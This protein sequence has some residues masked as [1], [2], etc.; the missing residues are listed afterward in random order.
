MGV[1]DFLNNFKSSNAKPII[2]GTGRSTA[3]KF[4]GK[5]SVLPIDSEKVRY[6]KNS[7]GSASRG[8]KPVTQSNAGATQ[9]KSSQPTTQS[10]TRVGAF[11]PKYLGY[12]YQDA[13]SPGSSDYYNYVDPETG[14]MTGTERNP[15]FEFDPWTNKNKEGRN[16]IEDMIHRSVSNNSGKTVANSTKATKVTKPVVSSEPELRE[17]PSIEDVYAKIEARNPGWR[18]PGAAVDSTVVNNPAVSAVDS[19]VVKPVVSAIDSVNVTK[20]LVGDTTTT[21]T[22]QPAVTTKQ[23]AAQQT[24]QPVAQKPAAQQSAGPSFSDWMR[25]QVKAGNYNTVQEWNGKKY[26]IKYGDEAMHNKMIGKQPNA[27]RTAEQYRRIESN[28]DWNG[29][30]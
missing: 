5:G 27:G 10:N 20:P 11:D 23:S 4:R 22:G 16:P 21:K 25:A 24:A 8:T 29:G 1:F 14:E 15:G 13:K 3:E 9:A 6:N 28:Q 30:K 19:A 17:A 2:G 26:H 12:I 7:A 18:R